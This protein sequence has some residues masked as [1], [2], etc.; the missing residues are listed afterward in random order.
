MPY[1]DDGDP[2]KAGKDGELRLK[3]W[4]DA[5]KL[6]Y[7]YVNQEEACF[8]SMFQG[9]IKRPD[10]LVL[11][12]SVGLIAVDAKN[13]KLRDE[14][15][16]TLGK[17]DELK[18]VLGFERVFRIPVWYAYMDRENDDCWYWISALKAAE[19]G[20][21]RKNHTTKVDYLA[22]PVKH[23]SEIRANDDLGK[24]YTQRHDSY[25]SVT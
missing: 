4:L 15:C 20:E 14:G 21:E 11:I 1:D 22:L 10:F 18:K 19:V 6:S 17:E 2:V 9:A 25:E 16:Y 23:F 24:L 13:H 5:N 12:D 3:Q 8:A 7:L